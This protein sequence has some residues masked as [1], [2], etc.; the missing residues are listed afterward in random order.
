M[1]QI[2]TFTV[3]LPLPDRKLSPNMMIA[4][5]GMRKAKAAAVKKY[6]AQACYKADEAQGRARPVCWPATRVDVV[7]Y[8]K[9]QRNRDEDNARGSLKSAMDGIAFSMGVNDSTF[10]AGTFEIR[11]DKDRPRVEITMHRRESI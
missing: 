7:W 8:D 10:R 11:F 4:S 6:K 5:I 3:V 2:S 1:N 9:Q